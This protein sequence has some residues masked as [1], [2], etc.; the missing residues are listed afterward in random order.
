MLA[1][2]F[3]WICEGLTSS[4]GDDWPKQKEE[5]MSEPMSTEK[6]EREREYLEQTTET[7]G[8]SVVLIGYYIRDA[9]SGRREADGDERAGVQ[10]VSMRSPIHHHQS[11][12]VCVE[13]A[14]SYLPPCENVA[15]LQL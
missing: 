3:I 13:G 2:R 5:Q 14:T 7:V 4:G 15:L 10:C 12:C 1:S 9:L 8:L 6:R 11:T